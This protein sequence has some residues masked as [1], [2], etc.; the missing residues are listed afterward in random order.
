MTGL[1]MAGAPELAC[2]RSSVSQ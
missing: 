1:M 2:R